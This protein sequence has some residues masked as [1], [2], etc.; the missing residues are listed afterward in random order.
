MFYQTIT[1]KIYLSSFRRENMLGCY[2]R[3][4]PP[5]TVLLK[6]R[7]ISEVKV[8]KSILRFPKCCLQNERQRNRVRQ[9][10]AGRPGSKFKCKYIQGQGTSLRR[11]HKNKHPRISPP[12]PPSPFCY[13]G[14]PKI[15][16]KIAIKKE[17][18]D[19]RNNGFPSQ[20]FQRNRSDRFK[21]RKHQSI[22]NQKQIPHKGHDAHF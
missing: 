9:G 10:Q 2:Q 21:K 20:Q 11:K 1:E 19:I 14:K 15:T 7:N 4:N 8:N 5:G 6:T 3:R 18:K 17:T 16:V 12:P 13:Q 22:E